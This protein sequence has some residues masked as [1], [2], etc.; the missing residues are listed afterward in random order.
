MI[1]WLKKIYFQLQVKLLIIFK[2]TVLF[3]KINQLGWYKNT[4]RQWVDDQHFS[5]ESKLLEVGC[6]TGALTGYIDNSGCIPTGIDFSSEMIEVAK[7]KNNGIDFLVEDVL[8]LSFKS[9]VF[10]VVIAASLIN[11]VSD[12]MKAMHELVRTC[13]KGGMISILVPSVKFNDENLHSLQ[14]SLENS[15]FSSAALD[16]WHNLAPKMKESDILDL[17][18]QAGLVEATTRTYLQG[19]VIS[20]SAMKP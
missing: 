3:D 5:A 6:A 7:V 2:P 8:D 19:M 18:Q 20:V 9:E 14:S 12:R 11:I 13:K 1:F 17:F 10:D 15:G 4:L 16:A